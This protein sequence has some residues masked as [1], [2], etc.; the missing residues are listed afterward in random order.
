MLAR[1]SRRILRIR[2]RVLNETNEFLE[3]DN[4]C[5]FGFSGP[6]SDDCFVCYEGCDKCTGEKSTKCR[7]CLGDYLFS[8]QTH[9]FP[10]AN[11]LNLAHL[12]T[13]HSVPTKT[14]NLAMFL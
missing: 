10:Q 4:S 12:V 2:L 3:C 13:T 9:Q 6:N 1:V 8:S 7:S 14:V 5:D 11:V